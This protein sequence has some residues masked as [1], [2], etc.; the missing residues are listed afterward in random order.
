MAHVVAHVVVGVVVG[1][2][3]VGAGAG[4]VVGGGTTCALAA[5]TRRSMQILPLQMALLHWSNQMAI[6]HWSN[7]FVSKM[8]STQILW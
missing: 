5:N 8:V 2:V 3:V 6:L 7:G 4:V 1:V